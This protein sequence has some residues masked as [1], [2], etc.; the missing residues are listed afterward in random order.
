MTLPIECEG[1]IIF[2]LHYD[3]KTFVFAWCTLLTNDQGCYLY[4]CFQTKKSW[5][6]VPIYT[7]GSADVDSPRGSVHKDT[8][9]HR[10]LY[11]KDH[12]VIVR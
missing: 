2:I 9:H 12:F 11:A 5:Y 4:Q 10:V 6:D 1:K 7:C 8:Q 3:K